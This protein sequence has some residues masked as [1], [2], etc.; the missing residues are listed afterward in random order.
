[1]DD[2]KHGILLVDSIRKYIDEVLLWCS[3][4]ALLGFLHLLSQLSKDRFEY[5]SFSP[6]TPIWSH[7]KLMGLLACIFALS[8]FLFLVS[9]F[10]GFFGGFNTYAFMTAEVVLLSIRTLHIILRYSLH[11]YDMRQEGS[12][13]VSLN[14]ATKMWEKRGPVVYY[15]ELGF[16]LTALIIDFVHHLHMLLWSN[17][18]LSMA[19]LVICMQLR[20][21]FQEIQDRYKKHRNYLLVRNHLEQNY[22]MASA[23]ELLENSDNCAICWEKMESARKLPCTHL[24]HNTCLQ[25]WLEQH[26]SCPTCRTTLSIH[27]SI[28]AQTNPSDMPDTI[29]PARRQLNHFFHFDGSRYVSWLPSFSV[30]VSHAQSLRMD[31]NATNSQLDANAR[32]VQQ[33]FPHI[34]ISIIMEDLRAT[35]SVE[36]TVENVIEGR[37]VPPPIYREPMPLPQPTNSNSLLQNLPEP[38]TSSTAKTWED[39]TSESADTDESS[40]FAG[41]FSKSSTER[42]RMLHKR[43]EHMIQLARKKYIEKQKTA[44]LQQEMAE[45]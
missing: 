43:K 4:F 37:L 41:R 12:G 10:V 8:G 36:L 30:E 9:A 32:Q 29:Q 23:E 6:T 18:F 44:V 35:R 7:V 24:F 21:L 31:T 1:M 45:S 39:V 3:W 13:A 40:N 38:S 42:E 14:D 16:E 5:L 15:V 22:P 28:T 26:T 2:D 19:S 33:L 27:S 20:Y 34:P 25:S 11:L 17:I